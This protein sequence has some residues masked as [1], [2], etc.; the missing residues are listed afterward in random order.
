MLVAAMRKL[1][2]TLNAMIKNNATFKENFVEIQN[3]NLTELNTV[4]FWREA[5]LNPAYSSSS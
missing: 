3:S 2:V 5:N 1:L 4:A